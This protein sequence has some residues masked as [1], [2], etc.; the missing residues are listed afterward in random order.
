[1]QAE[2]A[3]RSGSRRVA[4]HPLIVAACLAIFALVIVVTYWLHVRSQSHAELLAHAVDVANRLA[5]L[6]VL[7][8]DAQR[9]QRS[10][11]LTGSA[12]DVDAFRGAAE[13]VMPALSGLKAATIDDPPQQQRISTLE[14]MIGRILDDLRESVRLYQA[15]EHPAA[16]A[17]VRSGNERAL[18]G[19]LS[20]ALDELTRDEERL[21]ELRTAEAAWTNFWALAL[22]RT[23]IAAI[24]LLA[25]ASAFMVRR[26]NRERETAFRALETSNTR[27]ER[28]VAERTAE[29]R[30]SAE[31]LEQTISGMPLAVIVTDLDANTVLANPAASRLLGISAGNRFAEWSKIHQVFLADEVTPIPLEQRTANRALRG[32]PVDNVEV[33]VRRAGSPKGIHLMANSRPLRDATGAVTGAVLVYHDVTETREIAHQ[34]RQAQKLEAIGQLTGGVAHDFNNIL[35]VITGTIDIL[36]RAVGHDPVLVS[37]ARMIDDAAD[38]GAEL[39]R[40]LVAF[41]RKQPLQPRATDLNTLVVDSA[42]LL[43]PTLGEQVHIEAALDA[44]VWPA[45]VDPSQLVAALINLALNARDAMPAGGKLTLTTGN[46]L[47]DRS[48]AETSVDVRPGDYVMVTVTDTGIGIPSA[49][50]D[51]VF[52]PFFTTKEV[53]KGTGLGLSMVYGFVKQSGGHIEIDSEEGRGTSIKLY[54]PRADD[55]AAPHGLSPDALPVGGDETILVV[56]DDPL[57]RASAIAQLDSLGYATLSVENAERALSIIE[58]GT[59]VDLLFTDMIMPG[60]ANGRELAEAARERR[61]GLKVLFTSG[62]SEDTIVHDGRLDPGVLLLAKPY[63]KADLARMVRV[64]LGPRNAAAPVA[65]A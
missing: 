1:M 55:V 60:G 27:L 37:I 24:I 30:S 12:A 62:Y 3:S 44:A 34:L 22:R 9:G 33:F 28:T 25:I 51:K 31:I 29:L 20:T 65:A 35:T 56:E 7:V 36:A 59:P 16:L 40:R 49:I 50:Q 53:G 47:L 15:G 48:H 14:P 39:T 5:D 13:T 43:R 11:L 4:L 19:E 18:M 63:R 38:R 10:Y 45:L 52:E 23:G 64:A 21:V 46:A 6:K 32:E 26:A 61:P 58:S 2:T 8:R 41:A 57:A 42:K 54:L 17:L